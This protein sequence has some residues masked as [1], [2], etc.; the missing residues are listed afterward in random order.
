MLKCDLDGV[1]YLVQKLHIDR[2]YTRAYFDIEFCEYRYFTVSLIQ[3]VLFNNCKIE[4]MIKNAPKDW[5]ALLNLVEKLA[6]S[7]YELSNIYYETK[8]LRRYC[9][10]SNFIDYVIES[11]ESASDRFYFGAIE[12]G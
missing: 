5:D 9:S 6:L 3:A 4:F 1:P 12:N 2:E 8:L 11:V 7:N 10:D